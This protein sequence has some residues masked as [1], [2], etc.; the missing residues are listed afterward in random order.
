M[1]DVKKWKRLAVVPLLV[2]GLCGV[3]LLVIMATSQ[4]SVSRS[5]ITASVDLYSSWGSK[6]DSA[7]VL[8]DATG[9]TIAPSSQGY[10]SSPGFRPLAW[11]Y[12]WTPGTLAPHPQPYTLTLV[13]HGQAVDSTVA[14]TWHSYRVTT[15]ANSQNEVLSSA[16]TMISA[17]YQTD[18]AHVMLLAILAWTLAKF[19]CY[20]APLAQRPSKWVP[21]TA[22]NAVVLPVTCYFALTLTGY[23]AFLPLLA[24]MVVFDFVQLRATTRTGGQAALLAA[25]ANVV[26]VIVVVIMGFQLG[27]IELFVNY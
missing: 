15:D 5:S 17:W 20:V 3:A 12:E 19:L 1:G 27:L 16:G 8:T 21:I 24:G 26:G 7:V 13:S 23:I 10:D 22:F 25:V 2:I 14:Q 4:F 9:A 11:M 6:N 18:T